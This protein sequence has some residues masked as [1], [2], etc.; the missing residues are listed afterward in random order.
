MLDLFCVLIHHISFQAD[1]YM[2]DFDSTHCVQLPARIF[3]L[4]WDIRL[5]AHQQ[6]HQSQL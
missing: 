6:I 3:Q 2:L 5:I 1:K 4:P